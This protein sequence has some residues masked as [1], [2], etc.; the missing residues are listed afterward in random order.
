MSAYPALPQEIA[1]QKVNAKQTF[2]K[3]VSGVWMTLAFIITY[4]VLISELIDEK[5]TK[6]RE[7]MK[8]RH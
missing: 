2:L 5:E 6:I 1:L 4:F 3:N 8:V 7:A